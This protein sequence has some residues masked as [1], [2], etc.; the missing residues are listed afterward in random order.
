MPSLVCKRC[1]AA[2]CNCGACGG[3]TRSNR[4]DGFVDLADVTADDLTF[5]YVSDPHKRIQSR[6]RISIPLFDRI[7]AAIADALDDLKRLGVVR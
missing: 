7:Y 6:R 1:N 5:R 3:D 2:T 4:G